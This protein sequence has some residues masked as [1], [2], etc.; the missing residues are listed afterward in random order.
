ML[1]TSIGRN[2]LTPDDIHLMMKQIKYNRR[3]IRQLK[4]SL[5]YPFNSLYY[6]IY[7]LLCPRRKVS[8]RYT[9]ELDTLRLAERGV[10]KF[11]DLKRF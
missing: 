2:H 4:V 6:P 7:R 11:Y 1:L 5:L 3:S 9:A 8:E 10:S